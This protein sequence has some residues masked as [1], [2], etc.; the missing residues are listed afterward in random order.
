MDLHNL[1]DGT[2][3]LRNPHLARL[4]HKAHLVER[5]GTGVQLI[6]DSC[7]EAGLRPPKYVEGNDLVKLIFYLEKETKEKQSSPESDVIAFLKLHKEMS[8][9]DAMNILQVS[10]NTATRMLNKF[11][12]QGMVVRTGKGPSV[13][14]KLS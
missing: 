3:F 9:Q 10:R 12:E 6:F 11:I 2:S 5:L 13:R 1:G 8:I 7:K 4:A 14:Y